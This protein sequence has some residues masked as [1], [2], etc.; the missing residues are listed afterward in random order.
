MTVGRGVGVF[1]GRATAMHVP[2][3]AG[4]AQNSLDSVHGR[5]QH[6]LSA[7]LAEA[8]S[9]PDSQATPLGLRVAV[10]VGVAVL[11]GGVGVSDGVAVKV[12]VDVAVGVAVGSARPTAVT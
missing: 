12:D 7:Q 4:R 11:T 1:V 5:S 10:G 9:L 3:L 8:H 2:M 6:T